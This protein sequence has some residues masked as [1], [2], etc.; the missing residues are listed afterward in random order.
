[1]LQ[2][3]SVSRFGELMNASHISLRDDYEV[4]VPPLDQLVAMLQETPSVFGA[5]LTGAGFGGA[6]V[7]LVASDQSRAIAQNVLER[8][9]RIH[10]PG[11]R[12]L[13]P[14]QVIPAPFNYPN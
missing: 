2:G 5:R 14:E 6:S 8:Y 1:M 4:S 7:A 12:I 10:S 13:V 9:R 3:I 11:G